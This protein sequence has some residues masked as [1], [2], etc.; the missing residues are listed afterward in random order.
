M[1]HIVIRDI[2]EASELDQATLDRIYGGTGFQALRGLSSQQAEN[3]DDTAVAL[4]L[5]TDL[6]R[7]IF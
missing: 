6:A 1:S 4:A 3:S 7:L 5:F 2:N